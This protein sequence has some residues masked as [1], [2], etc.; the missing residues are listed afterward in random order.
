MSH[1]AERRTFL[2]R[3]SKGLMAAGLASCAGIPVFTTSAVGGRISIYLGQFPDLETP[4]KGIVV[5][6]EQAAEPIIL[7]ALAGGRF[8][9]LSGVYTHLA[10]SVRLSAHGLSCPC[11]GSTFAL[12]GR[13][14]RGPAPDDL[15]TYPTVLS[16][17]SVVITLN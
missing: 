11:H 12:D 5:R 7:L 4:G 9:A 2:E 1:D 6:A 10:C 13:A 17:N 15:H 14:T 8:R 16:D 3:A